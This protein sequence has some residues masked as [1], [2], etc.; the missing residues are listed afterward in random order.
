MFAV[1]WMESISLA[2]RNSTV[3]C[4]GHMKKDNADWINCCIAV[5]LEEITQTGCL[6]SSGLSREYT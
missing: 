1:A 6:E 3:K 4:T 2:I 5:E